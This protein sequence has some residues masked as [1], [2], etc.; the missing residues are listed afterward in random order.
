MK[1]LS[2][3]VVIERLKSDFIIGSYENNNLIGIGGLTRFAGSKLQHRALLWGMYVRS[4]YRGKNVAN[5]IMSLLIGHATDSKI[6]RV[7]LTVVSSNLRAIS[8]YKK[9]KF[10]SYGFDPYAVK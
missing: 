7:I 9:W 4:E 6:E 10:I 5:T 2:K 1:K 8:F 3:S